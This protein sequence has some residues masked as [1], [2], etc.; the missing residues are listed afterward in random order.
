[1]FKKAKHNGLAE[2][3]IIFLIHIQ[4]LL[5]RASFDIVA[6]VDFDL[7]FWI[8]MSV[9]ST[10]KDLTLLQRLDPAARRGGG[11]SLRPTWR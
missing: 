5:K 10:W 3:S 9:L 8:K 4:D 2:V 1:L 7:V 11:D 6:E